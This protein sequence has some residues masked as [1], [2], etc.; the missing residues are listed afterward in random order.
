[1]QRYPKIMSYLNIDYF[2][3]FLSYHKF[4]EII[5]KFQLNKKNVIYKI[6]NQC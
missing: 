1:M 3:K 5:E 4:C 2:K 6:R